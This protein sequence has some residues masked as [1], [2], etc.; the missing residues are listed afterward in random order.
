[1]SQPN[2]L[3]RQREFFSKE[4]SVTMRLDRALVTKKYIQGFAANIIN[5]ASVPFQAWRMIEACQ[6]NGS[7]F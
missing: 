2:P 7:F 3:L 6:K 1:M 4:D 5:R